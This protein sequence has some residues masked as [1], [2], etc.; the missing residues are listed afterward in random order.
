MAT[1]GA[2]HR[3][4]QLKH[5][6]ST[7]V[8]N[9]EIVWHHALP[10]E[11][12]DDATDGGAQDGEVVERGTG[13]GGQS[14]LGALCPLRGAPA[15]PRL[16]AWLALRGQAQELLAVGRSGRE[17]NALRYPAPPGTSQLGCRCP[18]RGLEGVRH[19]ASSRR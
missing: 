18:K 17:L 10:D 6:L 5:K 14:S 12:G 11:G 19:R 16:S 3:L 1:P 8:V 2:P 9:R 13:S 4:M 15:G 7:T